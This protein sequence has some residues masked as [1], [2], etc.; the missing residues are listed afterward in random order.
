VKTVVKKIFF[1][2]VLIAGLSLTSMAQRGDDQKKPPPKG[3]TPVINPGHGKPPPREN[4]KGG[5]KPKKP[6]G[7][8][9]FLFNSL[10]REDLA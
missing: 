8:E 7:G 10:K 5:E 3:N 6:G 1:M 2:F 9:A 4:P